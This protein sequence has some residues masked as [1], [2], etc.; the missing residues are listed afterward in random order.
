MAVSG[1]GC[2][3]ETF[4]RDTRMGERREVGVFMREA[5]VSDELGGFGH[6]RAACEMGFRKL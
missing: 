2:A 4:A 1:W 3:G 6:L 5:Y